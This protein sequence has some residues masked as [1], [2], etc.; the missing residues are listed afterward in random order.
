MDSW[1]LVVLISWG[2]E[3]KVIVLGC[4]WWWVK[5]LAYHQKKNT[6]IMGTPIVG[7]YGTFAF[8]LAIYIRW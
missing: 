5:F 7:N 1:L 2:G 6:H 3:S 4:F 8:G